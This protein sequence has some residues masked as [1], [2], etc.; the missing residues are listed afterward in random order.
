MYFETQQ[1]VR[2]FQQKKI[3][4]EFGDYVKQLRSASSSSTST[5][6]RSD[7]VQNLI[8]QYTNS[9]H[10]V[11][12]PITPQQIFS[13]PSA[14]PQ[15][16]PHTIYYPPATPPQPMYMLV[17]PTSPYVAPPPLISSP[18]MMYI[19]PQTSP[20]PPTQP[21]YYLPAQTTPPVPSNPAIT[22]PAPPPQQN[23]YI[24][25]SND[26]GEKK[27]TAAD[28]TQ[29]TSTEP[30]TNAVSD[31]QN[32]YAEYLTEKLERMIREEKEK[33][34]KMKKSKTTES[35]K[36]DK[37]RSSKPDSQEKIDGKE[38]KSRNENSKTK[39]ESNDAT[40]K[41]SNKKKKPTQQKTAAESRT[42]L[43]ST[44]TTMI[45]MPKNTSAVLPKKRSRNSLSTDEDRTSK[46]SRKEKHI[47]DVGEVSE[48]DYEDEY[49]TILVN[50]RKIPSLRRTLFSPKTISEAL[51]QRIKSTKKFKWSKP[52]ETP[53]FR[54]KNLQQKKKKK[55]IRM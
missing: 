13:S 21:M 51:L 19:P 39:D 35:S 53:L 46:K 48:S 50:R 8:P 37:K 28:V 52:A 11:Q 3:L 18:N 14:A 9:P 23:F 6:I 17:Q 10:V 30:K 1:R 40:L 38:S 42:S 4:M 22:T 54:Q 41:L 29:T 24:T 25:N 44:S 16:S 2:Q 15:Y 55:K 47:D 20:Y 43:P 27:P 49:A 26:T 5:P 31:K 7:M 33:R 45:E 32:Y 34:S 36:V 12:H